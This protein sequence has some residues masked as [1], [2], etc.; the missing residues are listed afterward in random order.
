MCLW[1]TSI[2]YNSKVFL[3]IA[4]SAHLLCLSAYYFLALSKRSKKITN[5]TT[6][7]WQRVPDLMPICGSCMQ[8]LSM[9]TWLDESGV[10]ASRMTYRHQLLHHRVALH[11]MQKAAL[12]AARTASSQPSWNFVRFISN[13]PNWTPCSLQYAA[14]FKT[15]IWVCAFL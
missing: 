14:E 7:C 10:T 8:L 4:K 11:V 12:D 9:M 5:Y 3:I 15:T 6:I 2:R 1:N 13:G